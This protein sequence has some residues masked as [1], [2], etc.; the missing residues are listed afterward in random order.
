MPLH[1]LLRSFSLS[2]LER[3]F[4]S[5]TALHNSNYSSSSL[6]SLLYENVLFQSRHHNWLYAIE[7]ENRVYFQR[8]TK[9]SKQEQNNQPFKLPNGIYF[10]TTEETVWVYE[11]VLQLKFP[12]N[13]GGKNVLH[14]RSGN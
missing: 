5:L 14:H 11:K 10:S 9:C 3:L 7:L 1:T 2:H 4:Q 13:T 8:A 6:Y 12:N